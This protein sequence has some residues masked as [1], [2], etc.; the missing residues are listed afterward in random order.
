MKSWVVQLERYDG[1]DNITT[2]TVE[3]ETAVDATIAAMGLLVADVRDPELHENLDDADSEDEI[4]QQTKL[5]RI[6]EG[7]IT[8]DNVRAEVGS[9]RDLRKGH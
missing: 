4:W 9:L 7:R 8:G 2:Y 3:A 6:W 5:F 1:D